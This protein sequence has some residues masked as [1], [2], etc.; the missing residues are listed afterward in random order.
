MMAARKPSG[1][2]A[3]RPALPEAA[4]LAAGQ[5]A[6]KAAEAKRPAAK[7]AS[8]KKAPKMANPPKA[9]PSKAAKPK[10]APTKE[11]S[12]KTAP[13]KAV[14]PKTA[15]TKEA[16]PKAA[17]PKKAPKK[18][19]PPKAAPPKEASPKA[20]P[21]KAAPSKAASPKKAPKM[22]APPKAPETGSAGAAPAGRTGRTDRTGGPARPGRPSEN[23]VLFVGAGPGRPDLITVAGLRAVE[24]ADLLVVAGSLV[25]PGIW[26]TR[27]EGC[28]VVDSAPLDLGEICRIMIAGHR[29]GEAVVRLH[30]GDPS[31]YGAIHEQME[32]LSEAA[33]PFEVIPGVTAAMAAAARLGLELT[34]PE[35][36]QTLI[37][38]RAAGRTPVP[39]GE[40]LAA[41]AGHGTSLALYLSAGRAE[42][43]AAALGGAHGPDSPVAVCVK[44]G[45][46]D[47][48]IVWTTA[49]DLPRTLGAAGIG[50]HALI[51]AGPAVAARRR[52]SPVPKSRLYDAGF[53][54]GH[55]PARPD[56]GSD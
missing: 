12:P 45:W 10:T 23:P 56:G 55:R 24:A 48:R 40:D 53:G 28:R 31:L 6:A 17:S 11:A 34:M 22:A 14:P 41:L 51:L 38:T 2:E 47:E 52:G 5:T 35:L 1:G 8:P 18:A 25:N 21:Q 4:A 50:R 33:V 43:V 15:P 20:A 27:R 37:V 19:A 13:K 32:I 30:T 44:V 42:E 26:A 3:A 46:P 36:T 16:S 54:H 39:A 7:A 49:A 9:A 29:R